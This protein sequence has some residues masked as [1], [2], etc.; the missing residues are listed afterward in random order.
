M[1][2][3]HLILEGL[4]VLGALVVLWALIVRLGWVGR[5]DL[6]QP[7]CRRCAAD[8][9]PV[10]RGLPE[11]RSRTDSIACPQCGGAL[12]ARAVRW[13][14]RRVPVVVLLLAAGLLI[15]TVG[16]RW[17]GWRLEARGSGLAVYS[18][19]WIV[20]RVRRDTARGAAAI[21]EREW[22]IL[23]ESLR[24]GRMT[25][26]QV[27]VI[28][29]H[30]ATSP[31]TPWR[32]R[33]W[34]WDNVESTFCTEACDRSSDASVRA[35]LA[36]AAGAAPTLRIDEVRRVPGGIEIEFWI[37]ADTLA[38]LNE[39]TGAVQSLIALRRVEVDGRRCEPRSGSTL[40]P[41]QAVISFGV[42]GGVRDANR[43]SSSA[44]SV[45]VVA[46]QADRDGTGPDPADPQPDPGEL[47]VELDVAVVNSRIAQAI[48]NGWFP[49]PSE[50]TRFAPVGRERLSAAI[51][52]PPR[53]TVAPI[54]D[55]E[56]R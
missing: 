56:R 41:Q 52:V 1:E 55:Q 53:P 35:A 54:S 6:R 36:R 28:G 10:A 5:P 33:S 14:P 18:A 24:D 7:R 34:L 45:V 40:M 16:L 48:K 47:S 4:A 46:S 23:L 20:E 15:A 37:S 9:R 21:S 44:W 29:K 3:T 19:P 43:G 38:G 42:L 12:V 25:E 39:T 8:L 22:P 17:H 27:A 31:G 26:S 32:K 50:W 30:L 11:P 49:P 13:A 51:V 2:Y